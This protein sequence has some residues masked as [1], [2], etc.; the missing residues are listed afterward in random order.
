MMGTSDEA[1][2]RALYHRVIDGWNVRSAKAVAAPFAENGV[3]IGFDGTEHVGRDGIRDDLKKI[4]DDH[5]TPAHVGKEGRL[6]ALG[7]SSAVLRAVAGMLPPGEK[8]LDPRLNAIQSMVATMSDDQWKIVLLQ[9][10]PAQFH[11][12]PDLVEMLT[13]ELRRVLRSTA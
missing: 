9:N 5:P 12:R 6:I 10:T 2:I 7:E 11:G 3:L 1:A 4:F 13:E 8:D